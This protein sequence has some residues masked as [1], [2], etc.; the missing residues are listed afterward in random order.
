MY[1]NWRRKGSG[2]QAK[3]D[4]SGSGSGAMILVKNQEKVLEKREGKV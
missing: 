4:N 2:H 3:V 1:E